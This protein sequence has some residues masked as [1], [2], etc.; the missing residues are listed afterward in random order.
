MTVTN[1]TGEGGG[2]PTDLPPLVPGTAN[3]AEL[4]ASARERMRRS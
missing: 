4:T 2:S 3:S 1:F